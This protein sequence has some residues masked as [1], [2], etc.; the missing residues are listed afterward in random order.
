MP[1]NPSTMK[2]PARCALAA[3]VILLGMSVFYFRERMLFIDAPHIL[4]HIVNEDALQVMEYRF[5]SAITQAV[6]WLA[7]RLRTPIAGLLVAY[8]ASFYAFFLAVA[9]VLF[10]RLRH[11]H[12]VILTALYFTLFVTDTFYW[13]NNEVHQ[14]IAWM[15]LAFGITWSMARR[16]MWQLVSVFIILFALALYTHPLVI[17]ATAYLWFFFL[18]DAATRP[19]TRRQ[20]IILSLCLV[21]LCVLKVFWST[22]H[23]WYDGKKIEMV[24]GFQPARL[25]GVLSSPQFRYFAKG[26]KD[27]YWLAAL[28]FLA[29]LIAA[30]RHKK[31]FAATWTILLTCGYL[32]LVCITYWDVA[33]D[34]FYMESQYM[35][36]TIIACTPFV[37]YLL[38]H[39]RARTA[40]IVVAAVLLIRVNDIIHSAPTFTHRVELLTAINKKM[41]EKNLTKVIIPAPEGAIDY[42]MIMTWALPSE[43]LLLSALEGDK[44]LRTFTYLSQEDLVH[45]RHV[46]KDTLLGSGEKRPASLVNFRYFHF[47]T[48]TEYQLIPLDSLMR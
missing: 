20:S 46:G 18:S 4:F 22:H 30:I 26:V 11:Y 32:A 31:Y 5:G 37:Y 43:A 13:S 23:G 7:A 21:A 14:G 36:L 35:P 25:A 10:Y 24:T 9:L 39:L 34:R 8:S 1:G 40:A 38:P 12:L 27:D 45:R 6:P 44:P 48:T 29:G 41:K 33:R 47:D 16:P 42:P 19:F 15:M 2:L 28:I 17:T 3:L